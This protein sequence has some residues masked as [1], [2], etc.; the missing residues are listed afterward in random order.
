MV[1]VEKERRKVFCNF[2]FGPGWLDGPAVSQW[3]SRGQFW[4]IPEKTDKTIFA[5]IQTQNSKEHIF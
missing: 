2:G 3:R 4:F 5:Q 1:L